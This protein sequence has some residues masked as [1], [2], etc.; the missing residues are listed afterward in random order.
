VTDPSSPLSLEVQAVE[1]LTPTIKSFRLL[2]DLGVSLPSFTAGAHLRVQV[3]LPD[4]RPDERAYSLIN[5]TRQGACYEIAVALDANSRGGSAFMHALE[6]GARLTVWPPKN[7]FPLE[8]EAHHR[9][10]IAGGIGI[11][12]ILSMVETL[13]AH[14]ASFEFHYGARSPELMAYRERL[15]SLCGDAANLYFDGGDPSKGMLLEDVIGEPSEG[16]HLYVCGPK[17][18]IDAVIATAKGRNWPSDR[19]HFELFA[20]PV[21]AASASGFEV[22]FVDSGMTLAVPA[23]KSILE[24]ME[25]AGLDPMYDC[26]RGECGVC[27]VELIEGD[28]EH[29]DYCLDEEQ[30]QESLC[31]CVSRARAGRLKLRA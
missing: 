25:E 8:R 18:L 20:N 6:E 1:R 9:V 11:T 21:D 27:A 24:V 13:V 14:R 7:D 16:R 4:G 2:P 5:S 3:T 26:R 29:E 10:L 31:V 30:Q 15:A 17:G 12:P 22:E 28:V 23:D 19:V